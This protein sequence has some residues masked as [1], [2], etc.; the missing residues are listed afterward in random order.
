M[1]AWLEISLVLFG[2]LDSLFAQVDDYSFFVQLPR[3]P[4]P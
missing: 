2:S 1:V 4:V 3:P